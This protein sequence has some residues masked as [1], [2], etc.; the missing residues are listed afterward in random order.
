MY[1]GHGFCNTCI[2]N[3]FQA[4]PPP[5]KCPTCRKRIQRKDAFQ[6]F[7]NPHRP[8][9]QPST[10]SA[11]RDSDV[12]IDFTLS[13]DPDSTLEHLSSLRKKT[14]KN[15]AELQRLKKRLEQLQQSL[16][17]ANEKHDELEDQHQELQREYDFLQAQHADLKSTCTAHENERRKAERLFVVL[18]KKYEVAESAEQTW[19]EKC[20]TAQKDARDARKEK[21]ELD[22]R[23]KELAER[24]R[25]FEHRA[26]KNKVA[27]SVHSFQQVWLIYLALAVRQV[28]REIQGSG[29]RERASSK[30]PTS[31]G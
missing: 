31:R 5:F 17:S 22:E 11:C 29:G 6:I 28:Q 21:E 9:S 14:R 16:L 13:D 10:Q 18:Q 4:G 23:M 30:N 7:L 8:L 15:A 3:L 25:E 12:D 19:R 20:K 27:V 1:L 24:T 26:H 2:E